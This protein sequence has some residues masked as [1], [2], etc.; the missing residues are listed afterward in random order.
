VRRASLHGG[1][2]PRKLPRPVPY[3]CGSRDHAHTPWIRHRH[4]GASDSLRSALGREGRVEFGTGRSSTWNELGGF[5]AA[6]DDTKKSWDEY[7][8]AI[9]KMWT[10]ERCS[11]NGSTV[12]LP[13]RMVLPKPWQKP[14]PPMWVAVTA[15]G[16]EIDAAER[17][18]GALILSH[19]DVT[20]AIPRFNA[21]RERIKTCEPVGAFVNNRIATVNWLYCHK[22]G[23]YA[24]RRGKELLES[25]SYT[26]A[27]TVEISE[28]YPSSNYTNIGLLGGLRAD[29]ESP[30]EK[31]KFASGLCFGSPDELFENLRVW[32]DAGV[33]QMIF[34]IQSRELLAQP[35]LL[36]SL[37]LFGS[38]VMPRLA[39][40]N[41]EQKREAAQTGEAA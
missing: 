2:Q 11:F 12:K 34:L 16:T 29:A 5:G 7:T 18:M 37:R 25:F 35:E 26:A 31:K 17:G 39:E 10:Q 30:G 9:P 28:G 4:F 21:Y 1:I 19:S 15:P 36:E 13:E 27:Q 23:E 3:G 8:R 41:L 14:H 22:D 24:R 38:K 40:Y 20:R 6:I 32:Q 33:D